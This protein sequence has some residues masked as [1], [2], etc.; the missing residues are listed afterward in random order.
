MGVLSALPIIAV[1]N[2]CC[3]LWVISGGAIAAIVRSGASRSR[4]AG[5]QGLCQFPLGLLRRLSISSSPCRSIYD[6]DGARNGAPVFEHGRHQDSAAISSV[7]IAG[8][9]RFAIS[10]S[11]A[12]R[13]RFFDQR[14]PTRVFRKREVRCA[15]DT[16]RLQLAHQLAGGVEGWLRS[17]HV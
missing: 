6:G 1:G 10:F 9:L 4:Y 8:P 14:S 7:Q 5:G 2:V 16:W 12:V 15:G 13:Q 11:R 3:C 17:R